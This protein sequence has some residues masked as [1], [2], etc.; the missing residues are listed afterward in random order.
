MSEYT[1]DERVVSMRFEDSNFQKGAKRAKKTLTEL[2]DAISMKNVPRESMRVFE[3][4]AENVE[5]IASK[6]YSIV[7][8]Y[9]D[10]IRQK[11]SD[12]LYD[13]TINSTLGQIE[14]GW[15]KFADKTTAVGTLVSQGNA[16]R[17]VNE[18]LEKLNWYTD[19]T[20]YNFVDMVSNIGKFTA[21]G[22]SLE[23]SEKAMM[24]IANWA[25]LSGQNAATASRAMYQLSQAMGAGVMRRQD[26]M[27]IQ[28][29]SMDTVEFRQ[30]C[31][32]AAVALGTLRKEAMVL[33]HQ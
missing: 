31:L 28:N 23:D 2:E 20:S 24:G 7:D 13:I 19:E 12:T 21:A 8:R 1:E 16:L 22:Q 11:V 26:Y 9:V 25:A 10:K 17:D 4:L 33:I 30:K 29:A 5:K 32:D 6:S 15:Q 18:Q 14:A 27:S 3:S